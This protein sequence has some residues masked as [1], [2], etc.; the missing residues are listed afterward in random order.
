MFFGK[1][2]PCN[3]IAM[4][5]KGIVNPVEAIKGKSMDVLS[6]YGTIYEDEEIDGSP[7]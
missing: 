2:I 1:K 7:Y 3:V 4:T 6:K 5:D